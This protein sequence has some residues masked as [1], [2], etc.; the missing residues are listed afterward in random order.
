MVD[1]YNHKK[2]IFYSACLG[3]IVG[4]GGTKFYYEELW[5]N[6]KNSWEKDPTIKNKAP[7]DFEFLFEEPYVEESDLSWEERISSKDMCEL[8]TLLYDAGTYR[9]SIDGL[10]GNQTASSVK[11]YERS[12]GRPETG[13]PSKA[14]FRKLAS[15]RPKFVEVFKPP[16]NGEIIYSTSKQ[17]VAPLTLKTSK[18]G[19]GYFV[20]LVNVRNNKDE[21]SFF[22]S[23]G[24]SASLKVPLGN[25]VIKY[26][27]GERWLSKNCLFGKKTTYSKTDKT[28][29]F[30]N[31]NGGINGYTIELILQRSG[32]LKTNQ[33]SSETW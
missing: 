13:V 15:Y 19:A 18:V 20:K 7:L 5:I 33:I 9:G 31:S 25:Y 17:R 32:N 16:T 6:I 26:A 28:F 30:Y 10:F 22:V 11:K 1:K 12:L 4:I 21:L 3:L 23:P 24:S 8:Q 29:N 27:N 14:I 2:Q